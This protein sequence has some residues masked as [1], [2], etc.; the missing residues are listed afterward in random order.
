MSAD[1]A[2]CE[3]VL[4]W[5]GRGRDGML[6]TQLLNRH[7]LRAAEC[8][9]IDELIERAP[10]VGCAVITA[11]MLTATARRALAEAL[12]AQPPWS[13]FPIILFAP[14]GVD[15]AD[16]ALEAVKLL[17]NISILERPVHS[18]TLISAVTAAL[19]GRR[20]QYQAREAIHGRDQ[21]L[22]MLGHELRNPLAAIILG[23]EMLPPTPDAESK[24][25]TIIER[26]ARH[27]ARLVDDLLD[28]AR[29]TSGKVTLQREPIDLELVIQRCVHGAELAAR[30]RAITL[31][32]TASEQ[33]L[34]IDGDLVRL[35]EVFNNLIANALKYSPEHSRVEIAARRDGDRCVVEVIDTGIGI[36]GDMLGRVFDLF[37]QAESTLDRSQGGLGVGLTLV[38]ALVELHGGSI[39]ARSDGLGLGTRFVVRFPLSAAP[40]R[41]TTPSHREVLA[42]EPVG[43]RV[44]LVEDNLDFLEMTKALLEASGALVE[45]ASDGNAGAALILT[46]QPDIAFVD[47]GLPGID[48][49][50]VARRIRANGN[51]SSYLVAISG[52]GQP[53]DHQRALAAGF[54]Q[55]LT[56]PV[57][58]AS[59]KQAIATSRSIPADA[60]QVSNLPRLRLTR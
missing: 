47:I 59:L 33:P 52:Y 22:A 21:F 27:L 56:K 43:V 17:V 29:V 41:P 36:A 54:D 1:C 10:H 24:Q 16:E 37:A 14:R 26:Q 34:V 50:Q 9:S 35:E 40:A 46:G 42:S 4:V 25:R 15:R 38:R 19:R 39:E 53:E 12:A 13:D 49:Y 2:D 18:G 31:H 6:A 8:P 30:A 44:V 20:R 60:D 55:H 11:E 57:T 7:G 28:V 51:T 48:G 5:A 58:A 3:L 23:L 32:A 45:T